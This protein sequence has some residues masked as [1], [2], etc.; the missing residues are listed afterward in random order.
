VFVVAA[1]GHHQ[2]VDLALQLCVLGHRRPQHLAEPFFSSPTRRS[3]A[4]NAL[5]RNQ[6]LA[7]NY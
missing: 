6:V 3:S 5:T 4:S 1:R 2:V 7:S